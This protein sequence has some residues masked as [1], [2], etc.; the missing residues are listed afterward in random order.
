MRRFTFDNAR[1]G[2]TSIALGVLSVVILV[3]GFLTPS[4]VLFLRVAALL[5]AMG[6]AFGV[7]S[8]KTKAGA[9]GLFVNVLV[10]IFVVLPF[11]VPPLPK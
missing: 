7:V 10:E 9:V 3:G 5:P 4:P 11:L 1:Y 8:I 2:L 6:F